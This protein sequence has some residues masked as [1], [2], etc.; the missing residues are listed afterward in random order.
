MIAGNAVI[1]GSAGSA[2]NGIFSC[3][4]ETVSPE[5][6]VCLLDQLSWGEQ[7][8][9][10]VHAHQIVE[11]DLVAAIISCCILV[12]GRASVRKRRTAN[13]KLLTANC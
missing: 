7:V 5:L 8:R 6:C 1:A 12:T 2:G 3:S 11:H 10:K 9:L 4:I 13:R